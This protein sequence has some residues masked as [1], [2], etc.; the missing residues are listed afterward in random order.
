M[1]LG[2]IA[3]ISLVVTSSAGHAA[4][5]PDELL[6]T[7]PDGGTPLAVLVVCND[8]QSGEGQSCYSGAEPGWL[9]GKPCG[10]CLIDS[11]FRPLLKYP[12]DLQITG[13]LMDPEG[14]AVK[15]RMVQVFLPVGWTVRARTSEQGT[16]RLLLGAT[17]DRKSKQP[18]VADLGTRIDTQTGKDPY[19]AM[20]LLPVAYKPCA[21][22]AVKPQGAKAKSPTKVR[23]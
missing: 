22:D 15:N 14:A 17:A 5:R 11:N 1:K 8:C 7:D 23:K 16:F 10:K 18:L 2:W 13:T 20:F 6:I 19:Y 4:Q 21:A 9:N 12:Y 3:A